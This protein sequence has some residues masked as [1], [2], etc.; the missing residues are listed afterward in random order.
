MDHRVRGSQIDDRETWGVER[1]YIQF[2][3]FLRQCGEGEH[4]FSFG[5]I[6]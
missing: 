5:D 2:E 6:G 4:T 3:V 1:R